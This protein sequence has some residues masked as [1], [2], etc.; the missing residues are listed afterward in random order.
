M[1]NLHRINNT[2]KVTLF[3]IIKNVDANLT[4]RVGTSFTPKSDADPST[5]VP[6][7]GSPLEEFYESQTIDSATAQDIYIPEWHVTNDARLDNADF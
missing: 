4:E 5:F 7:E 1:G 6:D 3:D 2:I